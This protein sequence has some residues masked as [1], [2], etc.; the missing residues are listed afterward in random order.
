MCL[1]CMTLI[2]PSTLL[3]LMSTMVP[4]MA[5]AHHGWFLKTIPMLTNSEAL[6]GGGGVVVD[7]TGP[8][9]CSRLGELSLDR[10]GILGVERLVDEG[11][12]QVLPRYGSS[13]SC[14][15]STSSAYDPRVS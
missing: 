14:R 15:L 6:L 3:I 11:G 5:G 4:S 1:G 2:I 9:E 10:T 8:R 13:E 7:V 12:Y